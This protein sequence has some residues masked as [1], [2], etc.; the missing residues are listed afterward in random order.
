M[1]L[2]QT[3][4]NLPATTSL[5]DLLGLILLLIIGILLFAAFFQTKVFRLGQRRW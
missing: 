2:V 4:T 3:L 5:N 1:E